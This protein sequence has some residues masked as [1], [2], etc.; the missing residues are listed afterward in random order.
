L[1]GNYVKITFLPRYPLPPVII[2]ELQA[3]TGNVPK[4]HVRKEC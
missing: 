3:L 4:E 2:K 1:R